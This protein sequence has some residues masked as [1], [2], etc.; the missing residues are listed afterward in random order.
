MKNVIVFIFTALMA[1]SCGNGG[2]SDDKKIQEVIDSKDL[3]KIKN[4]RAEV[5]AV[6]E[7]YAKELKALDEAIAQLDTVRKVPLVSV[8]SVKDTLFKHHIEIQ[9]SVDTKENILVYPQF[10]GAVVSLNVKAGQKVSKGQVLA[11]IEDGGLRSQLAQLETQASLA[12]TTYERQSRLW[13]QK[14]GSEIQYLQAKTNMEST[15]KMVAQLRA[16]VE[17]TLVK[18]PFSGYADQVMI[19][20]GQVVSPGVPLIR[21]VNL[22]DMFVS[23]SV[24][25]GYLSR[26]KVGTTVEVF[27]KTIGKNYAGKVRQ[28]GNYINPNNRSFD[29]EIA[30]PNSDNLLRPN[31]VAVLKIEDYVNAKAVVVPENIVQENANGEKI[32]FKVETPDAKGVAKVVKQ[33]VVLGQTA[34]SLVEVKSGLTA[35][36]LIVKEGVKGLSD[37][38][39]VQVI[40]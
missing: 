14:I 21:V 16:Q 25:E 19:E 29:I 10:S 3:L 30:I 9:G 12:K 35:N 27:V 26:L 11:T 37:G 40:K 36:T 31:Q 23:A 32:I 28:I 20:A 13:N 17:K 5:Q 22:S 38:S 7:K 34:N 1:I 2:A 15:Q 39:K 33:V 24:P 8:V 6:Y 18:A 4:K